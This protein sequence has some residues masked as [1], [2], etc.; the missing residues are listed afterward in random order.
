MGGVVLFFVDLNGSSIQVYGVMDA[1]GG[2]LST[3]QQ[4]SET[5]LSSVGSAG[6]NGSIPAEQTS[7]KRTLCVKEALGDLPRVIGGSPVL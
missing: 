6:V 2:D 4:W 3:L 5:D 1:S 7:V